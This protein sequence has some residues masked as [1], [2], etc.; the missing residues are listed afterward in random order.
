MRKVGFNI[1]FIKTRNIKTLK[2]IIKIATIKRGI[3]NGIV[4]LLIK[5]FKNYFFVWKFLKF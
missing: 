1:N 2:Q 3:S 4:M 5:Y